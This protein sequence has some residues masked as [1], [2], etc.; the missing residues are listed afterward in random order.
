MK[1]M[2]GVTV[3]VI[4]ALLGLW[5]GSRLAVASPDHDRAR[6]ALQSGEILP[7]DKIL[8]A[9]AE[10]H[11]GQ[12]LEVELEDERVGGERIWVYE[13]KALAPDGKIFKVMVNARTAEVLSMRTRDRERSR[14]SE[15]T[16]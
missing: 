3:A 1:K 4:L 5:A 9:T 2:V 16:K 10:K 11:P 6:K 14:H 15:S 7:L 12:V 8:A 13:I